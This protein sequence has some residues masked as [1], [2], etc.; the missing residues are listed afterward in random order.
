MSTISCQ[1]SFGHESC[2][3]NPNQLEHEGHKAAPNSYE[4]SKNKVYLRK[5]LRQQGKLNTG[6]VYNFKK[7][8]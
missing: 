2:G 5:I 6:P 8:R 1:N 3:F 4:R 7:G